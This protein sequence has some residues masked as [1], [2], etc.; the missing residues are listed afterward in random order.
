MKSTDAV[1]LDARPCAVISTSITSHD[2]VIK[3]PN[4]VVLIQHVCNTAQVTLENM[5]LTFRVEH[6]N[7]IVHACDDIKASA[8]TYEGE[9]F[10]TTPS[11]KLKSVEL[12]GV[13][14]GSSDVVNLENHLDDLRGEHDLLL[15]GHQR[16]DH[17]L[18]LHVCQQARKRPQ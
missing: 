11:Y 7:Q 14:V 2:H 4:G 13:R 17:I 5:Q 1:C 9:K 8:H 3:I 12:S 18:L 15:L 16:L 6:H 10:P